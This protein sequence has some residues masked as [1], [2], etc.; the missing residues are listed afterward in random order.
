MIKMPS[1]N[2]VAQTTF[3]FAVLFIALSL[4]FTSM[5][6]WFRRGIFS[7]VKNYQAEIADETCPAGPDG[8]TGGGGGGYKPPPPE[9]PFNSEDDPFSNNYDPR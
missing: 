1:S 2:K 5:Y 6:V 7:T 9:T 8:D 4:T 3:E